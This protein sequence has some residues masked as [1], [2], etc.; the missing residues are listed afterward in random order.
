MS[1]L[2]NAS[3]FHC[4]L[5]LVTHPSY[6]LIAYSVPL[7]FFLQFILTFSFL[8]LELVFFIQGVSDQDCALHSSRIL[9]SNSDF[10]N[11][12]VTK[13]YCAL[14]VADLASFLRYSILNFIIQFKY[15]L[16]NF[17]DITEY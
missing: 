4:P 1:S 2:K 10:V 16:L 15:L 12:V 13:S 8:S 14:Q 7:F 11:T 6:V 17:R 9:Q 5:C 3:Y